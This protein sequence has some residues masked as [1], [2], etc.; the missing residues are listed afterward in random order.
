MSEE[1]KCPKCGCEVTFK[2]DGFT[3]LAKE[4]GIWDFHSQ[5]Q[6]LESQLAQRDKEIKRLDE[7]VF[8]YESIQWPVN[9]TLLEK[10]KRLRE[11]IVGRYAALI[12]TGLYMLE[13]ACYGDELHYELADSLG[14]SPEP[15]EI[16]TLMEKIEAAE[17]GKENSD[18]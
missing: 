2:A 5:A 16:R 12:N 1:Q 10:N 9:L 11:F 13:S 18:G 7:L 4:D 15:E 8:A 14:G 3:M 17:A 6:C